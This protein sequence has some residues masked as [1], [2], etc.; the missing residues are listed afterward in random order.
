MS[1]YTLHPAAFTD[2]DDIREFIAEDNQ[3]AAGG[4]SRKSLKRFVP[5]CVSASGLQTS[6]SDLPP[7]TIYA[8]A[9]IRDCLRAGQTAIMDPRR[10]PRPP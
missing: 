2:L 7:I 1:G 9:G 5:G 8:G 4:S 6:E 10:H 3:D